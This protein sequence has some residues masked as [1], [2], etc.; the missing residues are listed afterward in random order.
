MYLRKYH[1][2]IQKIK[3]NQN[4]RKIQRFIKVKLRKYFDKRKLII[5]GIEQFNLYIKKQCLYIIKDKAKNNLLTKV[6]KNSLKRLEKNNKNILLNYLSKW[7][8]I[9]TEIEKNEAAMKLQNLFRTHKSKKKLSNLEKRE[10][11]LINKHK[12]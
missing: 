11:K 1:R 6:L 2:N 12:K 5:S 4:A 7:R 8:N 9:V 3:N 10:E